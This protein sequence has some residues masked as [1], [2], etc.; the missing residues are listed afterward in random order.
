MDALS[1]VHPDRSTSYPSGL[2]LGLGLSA[3][4]GP[5]FELVPTIVRVI[6]RVRVKV[7]R[8]LSVFQ[9]SN[10]VTVKVRALLRGGFM[11]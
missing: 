11:S 4:L 8:M 5:W 1:A 10:P 9:G 7:R 6:V 2:G 3:K